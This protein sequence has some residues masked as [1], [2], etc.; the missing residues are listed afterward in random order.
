MVFVIV[1]WYICDSHTVKV[2]SGMILD[3][4]GEAQLAAIKSLHNNH[5]ITIKKLANTWS[6]RTMK[7]Y[8]DQTVTGN[9]ILSNYVV[10]LGWLY[11]LF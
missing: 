6:N 11:V 5:T 3:E 10:C 9:W 1:I 8:G 4:E 7:I 2:E